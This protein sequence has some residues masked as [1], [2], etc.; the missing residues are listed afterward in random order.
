MSIDSRIESSV[1]VSHVEEFDEMHELVC[2]YHG[3]VLPLDVTHASDASLEDGRIEVGATHQPPT[4]WQ[5]RTKVVETA[6]G[7]A[8]NTI[9][10]TIYRDGEDDYV[11]VV[12]EEVRRGEADDA[13]PTNHPMSEPIEL[14][15]D[16]RDDALLE[17]YEALDALEEV[18][19]RM[20]DRVRLNQR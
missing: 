16:H 5:R 12:R 7:V 10:T 13:E 14:G 17:I 20:D 9:T 2:D 8:L 4:I 11:R 18:E 15:G 19:D 1:P 6:G 3:D